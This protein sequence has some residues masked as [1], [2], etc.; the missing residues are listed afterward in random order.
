MEE[1]S[2]C[3]IMDSEVFSDLANPELGFYPKN[4]FESL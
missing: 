3:D 2:E 4:Q 1:V